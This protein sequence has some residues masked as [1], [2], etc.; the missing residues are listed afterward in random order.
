MYQEKGRR[1]KNL[2]FE[3]FFYPNQ[4]VTCRTLQAESSRKNGGIFLEVFVYI[5]I[6]SKDNLLSA[7][8][9]YIIPINVISTS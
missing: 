9:L 8:F 4:G 5:L 1:P 3:L 7:S 6:S 2:D